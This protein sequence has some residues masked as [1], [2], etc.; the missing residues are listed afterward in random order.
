MTTRKATVMFTIILVLRIALAMYVQL[1]QLME[2]N[3]SWKPRDM[4]V[5]DCMTRNSDEGNSSGFFY[6][7]R[8]KIILRFL[9]V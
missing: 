7:F 2:K 4:R 5:K 1:S 6:N 9:A 8:I 3:I